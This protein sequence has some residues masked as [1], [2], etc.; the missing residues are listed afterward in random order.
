MKRYSN[1]HVVR[2]M[3]IKTRYNFTTIITA[4]IRNLGN[5]SVR[6]DV[7]CYYQ[8]KLV[9]PFQQIKYM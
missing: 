4:K 2:K 7:N 8:Y 3:R 5:S 6:K 1:L 9:Q